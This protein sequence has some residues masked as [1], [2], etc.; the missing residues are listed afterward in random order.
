MLVVKNLGHTVAAQIDTRYE[1][2]KETGKGGVCSRLGEERA[3]R[4]DERVVPD[5][6]LQHTAARS[7]EIDAKMGENN[8]PMYHQSKANPRKR[9]ET[10]QARERSSER[11]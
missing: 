1:S 7:K 10:A 2:C 9:D 4:D 5:E 6:R 11:V 8:A 3:E